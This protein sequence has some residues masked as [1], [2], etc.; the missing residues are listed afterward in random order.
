MADV[1]SAVF[2][3]ASSSRAAALPVKWAG[4][5]GLRST[6]ARS[7][8]VISMQ[9]RY[10]IRAPRCLIELTAGHC[11]DDQE[12]LFAGGHRLGQWTVRRVERQVLLACEEPHQRAPLSSG[13][14]PDRAAKN[15]E[16]RFERVEDRRRRDLTLD[17][18]LHLA[19]DLGEIPQMR[20]EDDTNHFRVCTSTEST[21]GKS[22]TM[23]LQLSPA[24][25]DAYTCP[26]VVPK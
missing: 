5:S 7:F 1:E 15:R 9:Q 13:L 10:A 16:A 11:P 8:G 20:R 26:P 25:A 4:S 17:L 24:S 21:A 2:C 19:F 14:V 3:A 18:E 22:R 23:G 12:R 6:S